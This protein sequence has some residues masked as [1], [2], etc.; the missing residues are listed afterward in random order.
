MAKVCPRCGEEMEEIVNE[1]D[2]SWWECPVCGP[3]GEEED[4]EDEENVGGE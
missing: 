2:M 4:G 1:D 3:M